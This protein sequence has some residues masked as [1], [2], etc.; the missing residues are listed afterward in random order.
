MDIVAL[1]PHADIVALTFD[2]LAA[3]AKMPTTLVALLAVPVTLSVTLTTAGLM[4]S[5]VKVLGVA[6]S[7]P[8]PQWIYAGFYPRIHDRNLDPSL[9]IGARVPESLA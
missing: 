4:L 1:N 8:L 7:L 6:V 9:M 3:P 2:N 5:A